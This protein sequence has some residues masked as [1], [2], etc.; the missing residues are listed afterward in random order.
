LFSCAAIEAQNA[1]KTKATEK[2]RI[3][4]SPEPIPNN[5]FAQLD[6]IAAL[7]IASYLVLGTKAGSKKPAQSPA[8]A[9][10]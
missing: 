1:N 9:Q 3:A 4:L 5:R 2:R 10:K 7:A 8:P 6:A